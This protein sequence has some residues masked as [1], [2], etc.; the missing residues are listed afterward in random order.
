MAGSSPHHK[1]RRKSRR[2][3]PRAVLHQ[4]MFAAAN[5]RFLRLLGYPSLKELE[6]VPFLDLVQ[7]PHRLDVR[8][9]LQHPE[10]AS[11]PHIPAELT[12]RTAN[13]EVIAAL[14][15]YE[16]LQFNNED[17]MEVTLS[18]GTAGARAFA[19][20]GEASE[21][22]PLLHPAQGEAPDG[23][24]GT[25]PRP[26]PATPRAFEETGL[27]HDKPAR[28]GGFLP[29]WFSIGIL[30]FLCIVPTTLLLH[31]K[32]NNAP[33]VYFPDD[34]PAVVADDALHKTFPS[35]QVIVLLFEG[36]DLFSDDFL[37]RFAT[38]GDRI[39]S[40]DL[41]D[42]VLSVTRL[43]QITGTEDGF[44]VRKLID[45]SKLHQTTPAERLARA[46]ADR[47]ARR[48]LVSPDGSALA[49]A[50]I[51]LASED[52]FH[53]RELQT[54][55]LQAVA[56]AG[57]GDHLTAVA[58]EIA[59]DVAELHSM[60]RDNLTFIPA[61]AVV[62]LALIW[63][64]FQRRL[65]VV[66]TLL[67][68]GA[69]N[70][71]AIVLFV[72]TGQPFTLVSSIIPPLLT[73]L[74]VATLIHLFNSLHYASQ[75]GLEGPERVTRAIQDIRRP[76]LFT[77]LT[78]AA[79]L[80]SLATSPIVP[81]AT[82]GLFSA[83]GIFLA[84]ILI[85]FLLPPLLIR[86]DT[87]PW[88]RGSRS[89]G[90]VD[91]IVRSSMGTGVRHPIT[92]SAVLVLLGALGAA[93]QLSQIK[94]ESNLHEFFRPQDK[95]RLDTDRI[96]AKLSGTNSLEVVFRSPDRDGLTDPSLLRKIR[97]L[98]S[99][100]ERLPEVDKSFSHA[101]FIEDMN[102][103]FQGGGR[104]AQRIPEDRRLI[105]QYL[106][107]YDG[108]D[109]FDFVDRNFQLA[110]VHLAINVHGAHETRRVMNAIRSYLEQQDF[111]KVQWEIAGLG[112]LF[113]DMER[114]LVRG[115]VYSLWGSL[116]MISVLFVIL[117][118]S[119]GAALLCM[120]PNLAPILF[121][122]IAMGL[123]GI[124]LDMG[125][126]MVA[127]VAVGIAVD[128]T[129]HLYHGFISRRREGIRPVAALARTYSQAGRAIV[130]TT[131]ILSAQF[132]VLILSPF[133]PTEHFGVLTSLGL[134]TGLA[135]DLVLLPALISLIYL[136]A[137]PGRHHP[138]PVSGWRGPSSHRLNRVSGST[139]AEPARTRCR[140]PPSG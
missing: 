50:V 6:A 131:I 77:T 123:F 28:R 51:P 125:T 36:N 82:F 93:T 106:L 91:R 62:G 42:K 57:L 9:H 90:W 86:W 109:L 45:P 3:A 8:K 44:A 89:L 110:H 92:V 5:R 94:V 54:F 67:I 64:M 38:L 114:L 98:Q 136:P 2:S 74:T 120:I 117:F 37:S 23:G 35:D 55:V 137:V 13:G 80:A 20:D 79:G 115:Q 30:L 119:L 27:S 63:W 60:L 24:A 14:A 1:D 68:L 25:P 7:P 78:T 121:I 83:A 41:V 95:V 70:A 135:F 128:D 105:S 12:L 132:S 84:Y 139:Q 127:S 43:D 56:E 111:G 17:C 21:A 126:V 46:T 59:V 11:S 97:Q 96:Q 69:V 39:V 101:D 122:F 85:I 129:I 31:L 4:G 47:F 73:A 16:R 107:V 99:W 140:K 34:A 40:S 32:V 104:A 61:T 18:P 103:A 130:T 108:K 10:K 81:V 124:W 75:R 134:I 49:M 118:R 112:R 138:N 72:L 133:V 76:V 116:A 53:R 100:V 33:K 58:G 15:R 102:A 22:P 65:A 29:P 66:L 88:P 71:S 52:S 113:S 26:A 87:L 19:S 48:T